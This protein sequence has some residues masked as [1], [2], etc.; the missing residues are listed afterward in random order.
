MIC[1]LERQEINPCLRICQNHVSVLI[2]KEEVEATFFL[3]PCGI[4]AM[5]GEERLLN[6]LKSKISRLIRE[7]RLKITFQICKTTYS[8][9]LIRLKDVQVKLGCIEISKRWLKW[10]NLLESKSVSLNQWIKS[11]VSWCVTYYRNFPLPPKNLVSNV[12]W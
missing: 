6:I 1:T 8:V 2:R 12:K 5:K 3:R 10:Q 11:I 9:A 7:P 4:C